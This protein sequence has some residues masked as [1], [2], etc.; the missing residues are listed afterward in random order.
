MNCDQSPVTQGHSVAK[1]LLL[2][3]PPPRAPMHSPLRGG[4]VT[5]QVHGA[6]LKK[7]FPLVTMELQ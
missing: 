3:P 7:M 6:G 1:Y 2:H 4:G 5:C